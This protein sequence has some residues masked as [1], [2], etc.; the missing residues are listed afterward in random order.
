M[1]HVLAAYDS[2][3]KDG[4]KRSE[5]VEELECSNCGK[6]MPLS[7]KPKQSY[8]RKS[9]TKKKGRKRWR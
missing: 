9:Y 3:D 8:S 7:K 4:N 2:F 6:S 5:F 1:A